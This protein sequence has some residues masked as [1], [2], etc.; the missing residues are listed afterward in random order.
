MLQHFQRYAAEGA[1]QVLK[2][3]G[4][5]TDVPPKIV[6]NFVAGALLSVVTGW[7]EDDLK[8]PPDDMVQMFYR[9]VKPSILGVLSLE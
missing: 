6:A 8:P 3:M 4:E 5:V 7:L 2:N 1:Y 9:L